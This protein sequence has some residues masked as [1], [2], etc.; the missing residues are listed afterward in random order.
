[1]KRGQLRDCFI[2]V[3]AKRLSAVDAEIDRSNQHEV[4]TTRDMVD[5]FL[6]RE[7]REEIPTVYIWM[8]GDQENL[9]VEGTATHYD[10]R[11]YQPHRSPEW[12][13]YY[14]T[15]PVTERMCEGDVLFLAGNDE[16]HLHF[17]VAPG[18]TT[19]EQQLCWL[20]DVQPGA[21]N[22][23]AARVVPAD[24]EELRFAGRYILEDLG[25]EVA[26][27]DAD[28]LDGIVDRYGLE[29]PTTDVFSARAR[30]TLPDVHAEDDPDLAL[31]AWLEHEEALFR[32]LER[33]IVSARLEEGFM[34]GD[35]ADVDGFIQYS[36]SVQNRRKSRMGHALEHHL[37]AVFDAHH[38][39][40]ERNVRTEHDN[41]P[42]FLF[43]GIDDYRTAP[44]EGLPH[45]R[46]LGAKSTCKDRWRQVLAE[47]ERIPDKHLLTLEPAISEAKT[48]QMEN[49]R[50]QLVVPQPIHETYTDGQQ[51]WLWNLAGFIRGLVR[52]D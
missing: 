20:F 16:E 27:P 7:R 46:M 26:D 13:L 24:G 12:R 40:Y 28:R 50:L 42:D 49:L 22:R 6:G 17:I 33:R 34:D 23:F 31:V 4:G 2:G 36:L 44:P 51:D 19:S 29:F 39:V 32:R 35:G 30:E 47:A 10:A 8:G 48:T 9:T 5:L 15:N 43:P 38:V 45:F 37:A 1:M 18:G 3:A 41:R 21:N 14:Q 11:E 25:I 52:W